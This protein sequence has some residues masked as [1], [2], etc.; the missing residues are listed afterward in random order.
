MFGLSGNLSTD[1]PNDQPTL[2][3]EWDLD[4]SVDSDDDGDATNDLDESGMEIW[5]KFDE[6]GERTIRLTVIDNDDAIST[7]DYTIAVM[8]GDG[9]LFSFFGSG[10][11]VSS[12]V[13]ILG[14]ILASLA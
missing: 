6:P 9:G 7:Q 2:R 14:L 13:I 11:M 8:E 1:T 12:I 10:S 5:I 3:Y 4:T